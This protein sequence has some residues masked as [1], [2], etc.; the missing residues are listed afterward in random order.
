MELLSERGVCR[1]VRLTFWNVCPFT[2][3]ELQIKGS[4]VQVGQMRGR[5]SGSYGIT[6][7]PSTTKMMSP[8]PHGVIIRQLL[9]FDAPS[10]TA[11]ARRSPT[12]PRTPS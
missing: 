1:V 8:T 6:L 2:G 11:F 12:F 10:S 7:A 4:L 5:A 9:S 3:F